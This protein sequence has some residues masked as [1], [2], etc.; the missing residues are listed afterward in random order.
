[1]LDKKLWPF[2]R[3][4]VGLAEWHAVRGPRRRVRCMKLSR[5]P[6]EGEDTASV[7]GEPGGSVQTQVD[8]AFGRQAIKRLFGQASAIMS[9]AALVA[10]SGSSTQPV[11]AATFEGIQRRDTPPRRR[12]RPWRHPP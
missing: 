8:S 6:G 5:L 12:H 11:A 2:L 7:S 4:S 9:A 10:R 3:W 1:M